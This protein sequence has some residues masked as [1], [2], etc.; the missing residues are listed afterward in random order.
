MSYEVSDLFIFDSGT[1]L[2]SS[3]RVTPHKLSIMALV[4]EYI[5]LMRV[6]PCDDSFDEENMLTDDDKRVFMVTLLSLLQGPDMDLKT[7]RSHI[8]H[9]LKPAL[10]NALYALL[11]AVSTQGVK[12]IND[13]FESNSKLLSSTA[14][15]PEVIKRESIMGLYIRRME[16]AY[17]EMSFT[18]LV[19]TYKKIQRYYEA[20]FPEKLEETDSDESVTKR[21]N[22]HL[23]LSEQ[24][25]NISQL[26]ERSILETLSGQSFFSRKQAEYFIANQALMLSHNELKGLPPDQLQQKISSILSANPDMAE[27]HFLSYM[28]S[29]RLREYCTALHNLYHYFDRKACTPNDGNPN[30]KKGN[31]DEVAMRYAALNLASL[32]FR[33]GNKEESK[34]ALKDAIRMAQESNDQVC[35][36]HALVWLNLLDDNEK[37][38]LQMERSIRKTIDLSLPNLTV[39]GLNSMSKQLGMNAE[40]PARVIYYFTQSNLINCMHSNYSMMSSGF[41][42]RAA[43]WG[44][45]GNR[46]LSNLD[47]Q[48]VLHLNTSINGVYYSGQSVCI[49]MCNIAQLHADAGQYSAANEIL[50]AAKLR[51]PVNTE[52]AFLWQSCQQRIMFTRAVLSGRLGEAE[53]VLMNLR[54]VDEPESKIRQGVL[55]RE[56]GQVAEAF[57]CLDALLTQC[58]KTGSGYT[59]DYRCRVLLELSSLY[60]ATGNHTSAIPHISDCTAHARLHHLQ[61]YE[62]LASAYL[63]FVQLNMQLPDQA[64]RLIETHL[65]RILTN[66]P[67]YEKARVLYV[68]ARCK[69]AAADKLKLEADKKSEQVSALDILSTASSLFHNVEAHRYEKDTL[70]YQAVLHHMMGDRQGRN[71]CAHGFNVL[72]KLYPTLSPLTVNII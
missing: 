65:L 47:S 54:A 41:T 44:F 2:Q 1:R 34:A 63:A 72:D 70:Y 37:P 23:G 6:S 59:A 60:I 43:M 67:V 14:D 19:D 52:H 56:K 13:F 69:V 64:V 33:F 7:L 4:Y 31:G 61:L 9:V 35:L 50:N 17:N 40:S 3:E 55:L 58:D 22:R 57:A 12:P 68:Y 32:Q 10:L 51:F 24:A 45:Y 15:E 62:A 18:Q 8:D 29:L 42:Q 46:E 5:H 11:R 49:A 26:N 20:G 53:Q 71:R 48:V 30:K 66:A 21:A 36:Q 28:N 39:L 16:L 25:L 27:G 38:V